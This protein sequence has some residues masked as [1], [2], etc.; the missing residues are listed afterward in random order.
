M[1]WWNGI[2]PYQSSAPYEQGLKN[3]KFWFDRINKYNREVSL[4]GDGVD[5]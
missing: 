4:W 1:L 5:F 3:G 2:T